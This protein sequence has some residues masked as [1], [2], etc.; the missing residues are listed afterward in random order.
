MTRYKGYYIDH[1]VFNSKAEIDAFRKEQAIN[2]YKT[3]C[4][5]FYEKTSMEA[6]AYMAGRE[7]QLHDVYGLTWEQIEDIENSVYAEYAA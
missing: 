1:V 2:G 5:L 4:R 7:K 6:A 3:A